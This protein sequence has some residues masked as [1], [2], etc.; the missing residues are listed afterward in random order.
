MD[1]QERIFELPQPPQ[2]PLALSL[3]PGI[4]LLG[5][6]LPQATASPGQE[7]PLTLYWRGEGAIDT[8]YTVFV[9]LLDGEGRVRGQR[10]RLPGRGRV[11]TSGWVEGQI[12][13]DEYA[14]PLDE[15]APPGVYRIE[16]GMYNARDMIRLPVF[17]AEAGRLP[18][19]RALLEQEVRVE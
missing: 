19:D 18:E 1:A 13:I 17:D 12:V 5:Y 2:Y 4:S 11:P 8:S 15:D 16:V 3:G 9:H 14:V 6:D 10:D 7:I